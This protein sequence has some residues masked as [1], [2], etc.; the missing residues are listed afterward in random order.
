MVGGIQHS[1]HEVVAEVGRG[2]KLVEDSVVNARQAGEAIAKL[3]EI[4]QEVSRL[5]GGVDDALREQA[6]ASNDVA[7]K[8]EDVAAQADE[9]TTIAHKT[10]SAADSMAKT[11]QGLQNLASRFR[12]E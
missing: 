10:S 4:A 12:N 1:T 3:R 9:A 7:K 11:A 6:S 5:I 2:V 8:V